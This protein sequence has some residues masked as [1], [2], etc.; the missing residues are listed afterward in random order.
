MAQNAR[1]VGP[2]HHPCTY[3]A[4]LRGPFIDG[5]ID[6]RLMQRDRRSDAANAAPDNADV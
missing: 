4:H 1:G 3:F 6:A 5:D 2:E